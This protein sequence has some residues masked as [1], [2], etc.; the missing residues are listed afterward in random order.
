MLAKALGVIELI[1]TVTKMGTVDWNQKRF[2]L[3]KEQVA[4]YL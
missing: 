4:P 2:D 3:I 1:V